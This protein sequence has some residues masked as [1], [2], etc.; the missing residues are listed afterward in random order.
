MLLQ[1]KYKMYASSTVN[2]L[3]CCRVSALLKKEHHL[4][5]ANSWNCLHGSNNGKVSSSKVSQ[6]KSRAPLRKSPTNSPASA[7]LA[8]SF[9]TPSS[10]APTKATICPSPAPG[11]ASGPLMAAQPLGKES[12][13]SP[14]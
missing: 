13:E 1:I 3:L 10:R 8:E 7:P 2:S 6:P 9:M 11:M 14:A 5:P 4:E 12:K